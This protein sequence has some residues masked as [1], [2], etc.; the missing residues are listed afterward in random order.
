MLTDFLLVLLAVLATIPARPT[1]AT[2]DFPDLTIKTRS[3]MAGDH[4]VI[5]TWYFKGPRMRSDLRDPDSTSPVALTNIYQCDQGVRILFDQSSKT[6][7]WV[8]ADPTKLQR[9]PSAVPEIPQ[10]GG[11]VTVTTDSVD[12]GERRTVG[13]YQARRVKTTITAEPGPEAVSRK[14]TTE[15]DGW[16][17]D[18]PGMYCQDASKQKMG[19]SM[20]WSGRRDRVL[21]KRLGTAPRG[22]VLEETTTKTEGERVIVTKIE[23]VEISEKAL[24]ESLFEVPAGYSPAPPKAAP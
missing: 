7:H 11:E 12:T 22:F 14:S 3:T 24:D 16:Y 20:A 17:L 9:T 2:P 21:F 15:I 8:P 19:W 6:Y 4:K 23:M 10:S 1:D 13:S 18:L 5:T